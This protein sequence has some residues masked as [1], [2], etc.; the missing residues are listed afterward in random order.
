[1][2]TVIRLF[3]LKNAIEPI[4]FH[5]IL[6]IKIS[7]IFLSSPKASSYIIKSDPD[8][9]NKYVCVFKKSLLFCFSTTKIAKARLGWPLVR[10]QWLSHDSSQSQ[11]ARVWCG[12]IVVKNLSIFCHQ[13]HVVFHI[14]RLTLWNVFVVNYNYTTV[15]KKKMSITLI[16][17]RLWRGFSVSAHFGSAIR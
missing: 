14:C 12:I 15:I 11:H 8:W 16:F 5:Q 9:Q 17:D 2:V 3:S 1:M 10:I 4:F 6:C 7:E 13:I